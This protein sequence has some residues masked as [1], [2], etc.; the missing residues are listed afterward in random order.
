MS[1]RAC[2]GSL[3]RAVLTRDKIRVLASDHGLGVVAEGLLD[4]LVPA[5]HLEPSPDGAHR[6]GGEPDLVAGETWPRSALPG[7]RGAMGGR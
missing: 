4:A 1:R 5:Y 3:P 7:E 6:V 2:A